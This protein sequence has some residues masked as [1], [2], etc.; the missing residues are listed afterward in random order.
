LRSAADN[1]SSGGGLHRRP[2]GRGAAIDHWTWDYTGYDPAE[3]GLREA[4]CTV[5]NGY[6]AT[7]GAAPESSADGTHY[8][9]TYAAGVY[10][11][12][13]TDIAGTTVE[14]E[15]M[16]NLPNW[17]PLTFRIDGQPWFDLESIDLLEYHQYLDLRRAVLVRRFRFR[18]PTGRTTAIAQ[19]RLAHMRLPHV[20]ALEV[21][22]LAENWS[23]R[24]ELRSGLDGGVDN[25]LVERYRDLAGHHL[26]L[27]AA[28]ELS[29]RCVVLDVRTNQSRIPVAMAARNDVYVGDEL[30]QAEYRLVTEGPWIGHD[31]AVDVREGQAVTLE[32][33][34][35]VFTGRDRA[36]SEP[37]LEAARWLP[38]LGRFSAL[39]DSHVLAWTHLWERFRI[40]LEC[41]PREMRVVRL[42][43]LH[44]LQTL[45]LNTAELDAGVPARG[46]HGE[47]YRGHVLWDELFVFPL[48]NLRI[49]ALT[50][51]LL[52]YRYRRLP[53]AREDAREQGRRGAMFPWQSG[54]D[55]REESQRLHL[56]PL[57]GRWIPDPTRLEHHVGLA[58]AYNTWQYYQATGDLEFL[59]DYGAEMM[60]E[61]ARFWADLAS[62][63]RASDRY[64]IRAVMGPDEFHSRYPDAP[65]DGIDN[66]AY[67]NVLAVWTLLR[68][69]D[70]LDALPDQS[71]SELT[72]R[73]DLR[74]EELHRWIDI[75]RKM[76]VPF[77]G[78]GIISQFEGYADL[79]ELDWTA[80]RRRYDNIQRLDRILEAEGDDVN[81]YQ[82]GKQADVLMLFYLLSADELR[83]LLERLGYQLDPD[84]IPRTIDYYLARTCHGSTLSA[85]VHA[86]VLAR[87]HRQRALEFFQ[88]ALRSDV[89]DIQG[90]T[91][92][93]GI[94]LAAMA[95]SVDLL[96]RCFSGLETRGDRLLLN[97][98]WPESLG[99]LELAVRYREHPLLLRIS[100]DRV[101]VSA[102][103]G[104]Q[105][106]VEI[107]C[108][109]QIT[110]L[111][112]GSTVH[113]PL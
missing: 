86:W 23:G 64:V 30:V 65:H 3:E 53:E 97:P 45:S 2:I 69:A 29:P 51:A 12:L 80:Y 39:L 56:N 35:T 108:R 92:A 7:R 89:T 101:D 109:E 104:M 83:P 1:A 94:H 88:N 14:N 49:P 78:D 84:A 62:Y 24:L 102:G 95:G 111:D 103:S 11:R 85:V 26:D 4:L 55:G 66:N 25:S 15:C 113:F 28:R 96:Q 110:R 43:L 76:F 9:G 5:G 61:I 37:A 75:S 57:S 18:D 67:T 79:A 33:T 50:R 36:I 87:A 74:S 42:H 17:L 59:T 10:N 81:R 22:V 46:L 68:A 63:D 8:P 48:L 40:E 60:V 31:I 70:A 19:R 90:G 6:L 73:L 20:C 98:Y 52:R 77:H 34:V 38:R 47:A 93:E 13:R 21:T 112:P 106:P 99:M 107:A 41:R 71:R 58:I 27:T 72:E 32:K 82:V 44:L 105:H 91:T 100:G 54:S 16:V